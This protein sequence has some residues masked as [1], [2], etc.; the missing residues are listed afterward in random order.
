M[1]WMGHHP[2][3]PDDTGEARDNAR[4]IENRRRSFSSIERMCAKT[5]GEVGGKVACQCVQ[6]L[7]F[8]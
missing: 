4:I 1:H 8:H 6:V 2:P 7:L 3:T 5:G